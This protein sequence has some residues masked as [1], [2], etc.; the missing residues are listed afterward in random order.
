MGTKIDNLAGAVP[1]KMPVG[2]YLQPH[3]ASD[4]FRP[5][6]Q[7][8]PMSKNG[9]CQYEISGGHAGALGGL[10]DEITNSKARG[11]YSLPLAILVYLI[12]CRVGQ[13]N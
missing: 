13:R 7:S 10:L 8:H 3:E 9:A 11:T 2:L 6:D 4:R 5:T 1:H 12:V